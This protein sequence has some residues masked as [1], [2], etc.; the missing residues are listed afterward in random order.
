MSKILPSKKETF[1]AINTEEFDEYYPILTSDRK[2]II[3]NR[4][5]R[6]TITDKFINRIYIYFIEGD[7]N[8]PNPRPLP[9]NNIE[10]RE[11]IITSINTNG[12]KILL[13]SKDNKDLYDVYESEWMIREY[14]APRKMYSQINSYADDRYAMY[15]HNDSL[16]YIISNRPGGYGGYDF[17]KINNTTNIIYE[18][19][20]NLGPVINTE[21]NENY[22]ATV[23]NTNIIFFASEGHLNI[24]ESDVF[25]TRLEYGQ[26]TRPINLGYPINTTANE[27]SFYPYPSGNMGLTSVKNKTW[28]IVITYLPPKAKSPAYIMEEKYLDDAGLGK[29]TVITPIDE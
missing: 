12:K 23:S 15:G 22:I 13:V 26:Y 17:W 14:T 16:I 7:T 19:M 21:Y 10:H 24:G 18:S 2:K 3:Y 11:F 9:L 25:K 6:D 20:I 4:L 5:E 27:N 1:T 29:I 28:D 8:G